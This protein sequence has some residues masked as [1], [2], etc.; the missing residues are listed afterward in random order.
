MSDGCGRAMAGINNSFAG[1]CHEFFGYP[2]DQGIMI[3]SGKVG[4]A[5]APVKKHITGNQQIIFLLNKARY[6]PENVPE[7]ER[8]TRTEFPKRTSSPSFNN[9]V[10]RRRLFGINGKKLSKMQGLF[11]QKNILFVYGK[12]NI[13]SRF[14][15]PVPCNMINMSVR[16]D[17]QN[18]LQCLSR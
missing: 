13:V 15:K 16:I 6:F 5:Y 8:P 1:Q 12:R 3:S 18:R 14:N 2:L 10:R 4:T 9:L 7:Y 17:Q 11:Q